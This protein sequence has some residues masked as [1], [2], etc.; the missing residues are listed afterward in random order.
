M[1]IATL[2]LSDMIAAAQAREA[3]SIA[4]VEVERQRRQQER[5]EELRENLIRLFGDLVAM[6]GITFEPVRHDSAIACFAYEGHAYHL[7]SGRHCWHL[8]RMDER[9]EDDER[10]LPG[11]EVY[12]S[13]R[14]DAAAN[15]DALL[16]ALVDLAAKPVLPPLPPMSG[17]STSTPPE[18]TLEERL[19]SVLREFIR[20]ESAE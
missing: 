19:L 7:S 4:N 18:P 12:A 6:L 15:Q 1:T 20:S 14:N 11:A 10:D 3:Q 2:S 17:R 5:I 16:L 9:D 8:T 13:Y